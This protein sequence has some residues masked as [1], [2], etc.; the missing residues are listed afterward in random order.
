MNKNIIQTKTKLTIIFTVIVSFVMIILWMSFFTFKY[1]KDVAI[2]TKAFNDFAHTIE[3]GNIDIDK[4]TKFWNFIWK[5]SN[6]NE[7]W[8]NEFI[9][10]NAKPSKKDSLWSF[11]YIKI[12]NN[13]VISY[14]IKTDIKDTFLNELYYLET[15]K[16]VIYEW[17]L[18]KIID[19]NYEQ[20]IIFKKLRYTLSDYF[21]DSL[22]YILIILIFSTILFFIWRI[23][24]DKTFIPVEENIKDMNNFI[25]NA[26]HELKTP[27]SVIDSNI[28]FI[29]D[30]KKYDETM[31]DEMK[32]ETK[33]LNTLIDDLIKLSDIWELKAH[34]EKINIE[35]LINEII[36]N[37]NDKISEK[38]ITITKKIEKKLYLEANRNY[39]YILLSNLIGN[40]IKYN[41]D[42]WEIIVTSQPWKIII[43]DTWIWIEKTDLEKIFD[44]FF[45]AD[46]SRNTPGFWIWLSL[47]KK[48]S[49]IYN[50]EIK[51]KSEIWKW[52]EFK[53]YF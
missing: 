27:I 12:R 42:N 38:N 9:R 50:W 51:V 52:S 20:I 28:Q 23:F 17:F 21:S 26:G 29:K 4:F 24:V 40:A 2:E 25:H 43:K 31:M 5:N 13:E 35:D 53:I 7:L 37:Y 47:V 3:F 15:K 39:L 1:Y 44:R 14:D 10:W 8:E 18:I 46:I 41:N 32:V 48:I 34:K 36:N 45:K 22:I 11:S 49:D 6:R 19:L 30:I 33:K 16:V